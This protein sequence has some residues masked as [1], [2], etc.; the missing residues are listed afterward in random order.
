MSKKNDSRERRKHRRFKTKKGAFA[1]SLPSFDK[2][3]QIKNISKGGLTFQYSENNGQPKDTFDEVEIFSISD[4]FFLRKLPVKIVL[5]YE[6]E[7]QVPFASFPTKQVSLQFE[8]MSHNQKVLL[9]YFL[10]KY[11]QK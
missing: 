5:D 3:G 10:K 7:A 1:V 4:N 2:L 6:L 8:K 9:D 11:T